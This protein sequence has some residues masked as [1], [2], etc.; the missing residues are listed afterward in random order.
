MSV[1][2]T[3]MRFALFAIFLT[4]LT[5]SAQTPA[6]SLMRLLPKADN[7]LRRIELY[8]QLA[9]EFIGSDAGRS[10]EFA[11]KAIE[12]SEK[13]G[14]RLG[15]ANAQMTLGNNHIV[16]GNYPKAIDAFQMAEQSYAKEAASSGS[17]EAKTG[18]ARAVGSMGV[19][20]SE[21]SNY[22]QA[23]GFDLRAIRLL[24][25]L[26]DRPRL[27]KMYNNTGIVYQALHQEVKALEYFIKAIDMQKSNPDS[28]VGITLT[29][30]GNIYLDRKD[31]DK[32]WEYYQKA[33][34]LFD[35]HPD[36][37]GRG[38]LHNNLGQYWM[39]KGDV[40]RAESEWLSALSAFRSIGDTFGSGDT[41]A[42]LGKL[43]LKQKDFSKAAHHASASLE[44]ARQLEVLEQ[45]VIAEKLLSEIYIAQNDPTRALEHQLRY[46]RAK[47]SLDSHE[48]IR[49]SVQ[50]ELNFEFEKKQALARQESEKRH[51]L[52]QEASKRKLLIAVFVGIL[53][54]LL[55]GIGFLIFNR[56]QL[57]KN[58]TLQ[59][60]LA[61][62]E[63]KA[64]HLQMNPHFVFNCLGSISA[65]IVN[66]GTDQAIKYLAKF[67][68]LMRLTLEYSKEQLIPIDREIEGLQNYLE[69]E[70]LRFNNSF[71]FEIVK[72]QEVEDDVVLP[73]LLLQPFVENAV[74]HGVVPI[75][76]GGLITVRFSVEGDFLRCSVTDNGI[77]IERSRLNKK[78]SVP[79]HKSMALDI[80]RKRLEMIRTVTARE[81]D[82]E[83]SQTADDAGEVTGTQ[84]VLRLPLQFKK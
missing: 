7:D 55:S 54:L 6:D 58:L 67:S 70:Q 50:A 17:A 14:H 42:F 82:V 2:T 65:F 41:H 29:N 4:S 5:V 75:K 49:E 45:E 38:E 33:E 52:E 39:E 37:R 60:E 47:D 63:Q 32:A 1:S 44:G 40:G 20:F 18:R 48:K 13:I 61:E 28:G 53:L 19:V 27:A 16:S 23:L 31:F 10:M 9:S 36:G 12:L 35:S 56:R 72:E 74:I 83:I 64:L 71:Q 79:V 84:V 62:Y 73:P 59:K 24:E 26:N 46:S 69:L 66:H 77:G 43:Y 80:T 22:A 78:N 57:K 51:L 30:V 15:K 76:T 3:A 68:K 8:N 34:A 81:A 25:E 11:G 21:Q